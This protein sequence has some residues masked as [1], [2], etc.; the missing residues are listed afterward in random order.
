MD[1]DQVIDMSLPWATTIESSQKMA[2]V[3]TT[4]GEGGPK[5]ERKEYVAICSF[6][7]KGKGRYPVV[8]R[9]KEKID[10]PNCGHALFW[11]TDNGRQHIDF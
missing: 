11:T 6:C 10:C 8:T 1:D 9:D 4:I 2:S 5:I 7:R 3:A